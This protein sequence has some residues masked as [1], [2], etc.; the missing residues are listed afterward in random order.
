MKEKNIIIVG[1]GFAGL[2]TALK[3]AR[4]LSSLPP[5]WRIILIDRRDL[6]LYTPALY[7]IA[8]MPRSL[9]PDDLLK[10]SVLIPLRDII[11]TR[12]IT[13]IRD[14]CIDLDV[15]SRTLTL[16]RAGKLQGEYL[17]L[18][19][20]SETNFFNIP[21][22][23]RYGHPLKTFDDALAIRNEL[24]SLLAKKDHI[25]VVIAGAGST[26]VE[27]SCEFINFICA[28]TS[29]SRVGTPL[30]PAAFTLFEASD[31]ILPGFNSW[32]TRRAAG[33]LADL[34]VMVKTKSPLVAVDERDI[35]LG[36]G[37]KVP[38]DLLIWT[39]GVR[40]PYLLKTLNI[41][42]DRTNAIATDADLFVGDT[43]EKVLAIGDNAAITNPENR[44]MI[45]RNVPA[46]QAEAAYAALR[47]A[48]SIRGLEQK[49]FRPRKRYPFILATGKKYAI[50]DLVVIRFSGFL[51]WAAKEFA[52][53][54]YLLSILPLK[55]ALRLWWTTVKLHSAND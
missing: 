52:Q 36:N 41:P 34:G 46:A 42:K 25:H 15:K 53:L 10:S 28:I 11:G 21:G 35:T 4:R 14:E 17:V 43:D 33:R 38:Y 32:I 22:L 51:G 6:H 39:G 26:G 2:Y 30:C 55:K 18:A 31:G 9:A 45:P 12:P 49:H 7:E 54:R 1:A 48:R 23:D 13:F 16:K 19:M 37:T 20:G 3:L 29:K 8:A 44:R 50:A 40:P 47:I 27:V 5:G 24:E